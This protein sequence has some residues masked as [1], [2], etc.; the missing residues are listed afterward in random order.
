MLR[1]PLRLLLVTIC[2]VA[3][4]GGAGGAATPEPVVIGMVAPLTGALSTVGSGHRAGAEAAVRE[5]NREGGVRGRR[6]VL[7]LFDDT[8]NPTP[9]LIRMQELASDPA[10]VAMIGSGF[11]ATAR[12]S[13]PIATSVG[14]PY[15]SMAPLHTLV[16]PPQPYVYTSGHTTRIVAYKLAAHLRATGVKRIALLRA[17]SPVGL[18]AEQVV[19]ELATR[20]GLEVVADHV[21][22]LTST[23]FIGELVALKSSNAQALWVWAVDAGAVTIT[24]EL[25][26]LQLPQRLILSHGVASPLYLRPA[27]PDSNG[28]TLAAPWSLVARSL[29]DSN[30]SKRLTLRIDRLVGVDVSTFAY[31]GYTGVMMLAQAMRANGVARESI[32][33]ALERMTFVGPEGIHRFSRFKHAGLSAKSLLLL[34]IRDCAPV[35]LSGQDLDG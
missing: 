31:N 24:K 22:P 3:L 19:K 9:G 23:T 20:Y 16:Y 12:A 15:I 26:Q 8:S 5:L 18:E 32:N 29:P 7:R 33:Q 11:A 10:V 34:R 13:A 17:N 35:P 14:L 30:P 1:V 4:P 25:R 27:C 2:V 28:A 6:V 21:Y